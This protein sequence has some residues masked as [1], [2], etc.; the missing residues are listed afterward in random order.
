[1][2]TYA[3]RTFGALLLEARGLLNDLVPISGLPR[4]TDNDLIEIVNEGILELKMKRP[5]AWLGFGLRKPMP[6]YT[7]PAASNVVMPF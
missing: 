6:K 3:N 5:D 7:M 1:M 2:P 4:F